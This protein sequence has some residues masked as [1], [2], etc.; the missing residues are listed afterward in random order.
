MKDEGKTREQLINEVA[1]LRERIAQLEAAEEGCEHVDVK[2][3]RDMDFLS[4]TAT[5]FVEL[6]SEENIYQFIGEKLKQLVG[7]AVVIINSFDKVSDSFC[8][9]AIVGF[10]KYIKSKPVLELLARVSL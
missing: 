6:A 7:N 5:E 8:T 10:G 1:E 2:H 9:R 3:T 4:R